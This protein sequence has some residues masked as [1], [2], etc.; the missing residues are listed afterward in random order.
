MTCMPG[1]LRF[2]NA[3]E[4]SPVSIRLQSILK[5]R[6][7]VQKYVRGC[8]RV[9]CTN[10]KFAILET[11]TNCSPFALIQA[12]SSEGCHARYLM[13]IPSQPAANSVSSVHGLHACI[14]PARMHWMHA[15]MS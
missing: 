2:S 10:A 15:H 5:L 1:R 14:Q 11:T 13:L 3:L 6:I 12:S 7:L 8:C 4:N 9:E